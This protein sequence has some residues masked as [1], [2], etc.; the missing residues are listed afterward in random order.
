MRTQLTGVPELARDGA[1]RAG[2]PAASAVAVAGLS[3]CY[4]T[5]Q[6][7]RGVSFT[8]GHGRSSR[9]WGRTAAHRRTGMSGMAAGSRYE[10]RVQV[11]LDEH[12]AAWFGG[13]MVSSDG[14]QTVIC[15]LVPDQAALH[16]LL[17]KV[18]DLGLVLISV[19]RID[20]D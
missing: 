12:W 13:L 9:C 6:A 14:D 15:G 7:V 16:G 10:I 2:S 19:H 4:G 1:A 3:K 5:V 18:H 11:V 17:T 8:V 20:P